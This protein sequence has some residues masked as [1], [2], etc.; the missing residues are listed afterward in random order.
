M[1]ARLRW[2]A[3]RRSVVVAV[4]GCVIRV[5]F[6]LSGHPRVF[7]FVPARAGPK[8]LTG[9][10]LTVAAIRG[11]GEGGSTSDAPPSSRTDRDNNLHTGVPGSACAV[12]LSPALSPSGSSGLAAQSRN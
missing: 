6:A 2:Q 9:G 11:K 5:R 10:S 12:R 4:I 7:D 1:H 3:L 8:H